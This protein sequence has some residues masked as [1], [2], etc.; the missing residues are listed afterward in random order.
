M[1]LRLSACQTC[2][3]PNSA[4]HLDAAGKVTGSFY[5]V[6]GDRDPGGLWHIVWQAACIYMLTAC[7]QATSHWLSELTAARCD[8]CRFLCAPLLL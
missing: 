3:G 7:V 8:G 4:P 6:L 5:R 2:A 1:Q